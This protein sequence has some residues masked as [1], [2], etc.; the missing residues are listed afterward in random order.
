M[1]VA[2]L[3]AAALHGASGLLAHQGGWDEFLWVLV[4]ILVMVGL[5]RVAATRVKNNARLA[6][7]ANQADTPGS[8]ERNIGTE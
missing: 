6:A 8:D 7:G 4:P 1:F 3:F 5:L 2:V